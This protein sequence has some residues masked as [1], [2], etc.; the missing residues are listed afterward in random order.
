[1]TSLVEKSREQEMFNRQLLATVEEQNKKILEQDQKILY[2]D[3]Q[4]LYQDQKILY[5][6]QK[7]EKLEQ[8]CHKPVNNGIMSTCNIRYVHIHED[9]LSAVEHSR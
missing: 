9:I 1:M 2:Q 7:I 6:N 4:I 3:Q 5:Q 8:S